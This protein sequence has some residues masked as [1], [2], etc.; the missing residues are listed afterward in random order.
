M[1]SFL[2]IISST[3][4]T[5]EDSVFV[6]ETATSVY[7]CVADGCSSGK[8]SHF[9]SRLFCY[10][11]EVSKLGVIT[12]DFV[13]R[14]IFSRLLT[15]ADVVAKP[16]DYFES[17]LL[18]FE[19]NKKTKQLRVR[20]FGDG[21]YY[22]NDVEYMIDQK[23]IPDYMA[24]HMRGDWEGFMKK[25]PEKIYDDVNSFKICSD[26]IKA[27]TISQFHDSDIKD[28]VAFL[29]HPP[30]SNNFL[31]LKWNILKRKHFILNDDLTIVSYV[32]E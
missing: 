4:N 12:D 7:G 11:A 8:H 16:I 9:A 28:P 32:Q 6:K 10:L 1:L 3:H 15:I 26:G 20:P 18:L 14:S 19:Y 29:F 23:N 24:H 17:T 21:A 25:Y 2:N 13:V 30:T 27:I 31:T 5:C 22:I